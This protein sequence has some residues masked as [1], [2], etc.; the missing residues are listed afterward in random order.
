M[1]MEPC[2]QNRWK[3]R[4]IAI[5]LQISL[6]YRANSEPKPFVKPHKKPRRPIF[7][8]MVAR[9][10]GGRH[11]HVTVLQN[12]MV[13]YVRTRFENGALQRSVMPRSFCFS[14]SWKL[15]SQRI[16]FEL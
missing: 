12:M 3:A 16:F 11:G 2:A 10:Y 15:T 5:V 1:K 4:I 8:Q 7:A 9:A 13:R 14:C 6:V